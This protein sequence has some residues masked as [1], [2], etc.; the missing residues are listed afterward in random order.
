MPRTRTLLSLALVVCTAATGVWWL[1]RPEPISVVLAT[2]NRG[3]VESTAANTR[4]GTVKACRRSYLAP[5]IGGQI[6]QMLVE[7]AQRV[8]TGQVLLSIWNEDLKAQL[9]LAESELKAAAAR[10]EEACLMAEVAEREANRLRRL[11]V[12]KAVSAEQLDQAVTEAKAREAGCR[13]S[14]AAAEVSRAQTQVAQAALDR[15]ILRAPFDGVVARVNGEL[16]EY[17]TPSP[18]GIPTLPAVDLIDT[19]CLY[20]E[21]PIDEVD[22]PAIRTEMPACVSLDAFPERICSGRVR[23]VAPYV[24]DLE[25]QAR[26]VEV[27]VELTKPGEIPNLLPGYSAD[28][29]V[30]LA[31]RDD[32]LRVPTEAVLEGHRVLL[33]QPDS[34]QIAERRIEPGLSNWSHTEVRSGLEEGERIVLSVDRQ[35]VAPGVRVVPEAESPT[36]T[37]GP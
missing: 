22:A 21:A 33:Y 5:A 2:V 25:K 24:L 28:I 15:T 16:G 34:G 6:A 27:E 7:E 18:P 9:L 10:A 3:R 35:G 29:E 30:V 13:A 31:A 1:S 26:T 37:A 17:I 14:R 4:A 32:V 11:S 20:V 8:K 19:T 23:R 36:E 12:K